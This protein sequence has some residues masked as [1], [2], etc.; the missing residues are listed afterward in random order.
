MKIGDTINEIP[1][2]LTDGAFDEIRD[3]C[4]LLVQEIIFK[5]DGNID[6]KCTV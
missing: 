3:L 5:K 4:K 1:K 2:I 6:V